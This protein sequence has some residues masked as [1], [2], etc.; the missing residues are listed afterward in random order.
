MMVPPLLTNAKEH[1][2]DRHWS[3]LIQRIKFADPVLFDLRYKML[4]TQE[5]F[6][7]LISKSSSRE[8]ICD[9][10]GIIGSWDHRKKDLLYDALWKY[11][12]E[13]MSMLEGRYQRM[14]DP[15]S[16]QSESTRISVH[17]R[18]KLI[19]LKNMVAK[20]IGILSP[21]MECHLCGKFQDSDSVLNPDVIGNI[22]RMELK[23]AGLFCCQKTGIK[24]Q[25]TGPVVI[26]Y[27]L[28][29]WS[30]HLEEIPA[31]KHEIIG[32]LFNI[33]ICEQSTAN[34][35]SAVY[36]PHYLCLRSFTGDPS[37]IKCAHFIDGNMAFKSPTRVEPFYIVLENPTFSCLGP[38]LSLVK[39]KIPIHGIVLIYFRIVCPGEPEYEEY[40][41]HLHLL[42]LIAHIGERLDKEKKTLGFQRVAKPPQTNDTV[43]TKTKYQITSRSQDYVHPKTLK[44]QSSHHS[45][46]FEFTEI[47]VRGNDIN[48]FLEVKEESTTEI[49]WD[50]ILTRGDIK[51][52]SRSVDQLR[53]N[54]GASSPLEHFVDKHRTALIERLSYVDPVLDDLLAQNLLTQEQY[55]NV[56]RKE[57]HQQKMRQLYQYTTSWGNPDKEKLYQAI[58]RC[59]K[60]LVIDLGGP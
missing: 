19:L 1:F 49:V 28:E 24:F 10:F 14:W 53:K 16:M 59:N 12:D 42:P 29:S 5:E 3:F 45:E 23:F 21:H 46:P 50:T 30:D 11:N 54:D 44:F 2:L 34:V 55:D 15:L 35:V 27:S 37:S 41:I 58:L 9:L 25:V 13:D 4:I 51:D 31:S 8:K 47:R 18:N 57:P 22:F 36:L 56:R 52:F 60:P 7:N 26:E 48:I 17:K 38:L 20:D 43:Y 6:Q 39:K 33:K 32:P 40:K